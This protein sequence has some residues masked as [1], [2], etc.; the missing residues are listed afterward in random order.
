MRLFVVIVLLVLQS[1]AFSANWEG[2]GQV[3]CG[4]LIASWVRK[5]PTPDELV[6]RGIVF[7]SPRDNQDFTYLGRGTY[8]QVWRGFAANNKGGRIPVIIKMTKPKKA[9]YLDRALIYIER[10][11]TLLSR[12]S[13]ETTHLIKS[14]DT[15]YLVTEVIPRDPQHPTEPAYTLFEILESPQLFSEDLA[16]LDS[17]KSLNARYAVARSIVAAMQ[18]LHEKRII[19]GDVQAKNILLAQR[20]DGSP[21]AHFIDYGFSSGPSVPPLSGTYGSRL[22]L[23]N[24]KGEAFLAKE[25]TPLRDWQAMRLVLLEV[26]SEKKM[27]VSNPETASRLSE[28]EFLLKS[29]LPLDSSN[30]AKWLTP[31][32]SRKQFLEQFAQEWTSTFK[33]TTDVDLKIDLISDLVLLNPAFGSEVLEHLPHEF[34]KVVIEDAVLG[35][36]KSF[37]KLPKVREIREKIGDPK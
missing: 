7:D 34:Q 28:M 32:K 2:V 10:E 17:G 36:F 3:S 19:H 26:F 35:E 21:F 29:S 1:L 27:T 37:L 13:P 4:T 6:R 23:K 20:Q 9:E 8:S 24:P 22:A 15:K 33:T 5:G 25:T 30:Y 16:H 18:A 31:I 11:H 14:G 12:I